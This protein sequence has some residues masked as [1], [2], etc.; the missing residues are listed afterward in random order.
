MPI[1]N[2]VIAGGGA[3]T[4]TGTMYI[5]SNGTYN[6]ADKAIA[7]VNVPVGAMPNYV[8]WRIVSNGTLS[9]SRGATGQ[10]V[11]STSPATDV[12]KYG[13][14]AIFYNAAGGMGTIAVD[15]SSL[16]SVSGNSAFEKAFEGNY[17]ITSFD[18]SNIKT[19][20]GQN[21]FM[22]AWAGYKAAWAVNTIS[23][24][25]LETVANFAF[26]NCLSGDNRIQTFNLPSLKNIRNYGLNS[27]F[28]DSSA[29]TTVVLGNTEHITLGTGVF[30][31][32]FS[33]C[34][35]NIDVYAPAAN[36][37]EIEAMS[38]YPAF[39]G[40]GTVTWHWQS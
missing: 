6:V 3:P 19:I 22:N 28:S 2:S 30:D 7:N 10:T 34:S 25:A 21:A 20:T 40:Y 26:Q 37:A 38:D 32:M 11:F 5:I 18:F 29:L 13:C 15:C 36:Q 39:G 8:V 33:G 12:S 24:P 35:Q 14:A 27:A 1:M 31:W 4:P 17:Q 16:T 9:C 23:F